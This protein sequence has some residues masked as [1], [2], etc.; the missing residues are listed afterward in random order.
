MAVVYH[1]AQL[2]VRRGARILWALR[3][4]EFRGHHVASA[5][6]EQAVGGQAVAARAPRLLIVGIEVLRHVVV[7][8]VADVGLVYAHAEGVGRDHDR[9]AVVYEF[10]LIARALRVG[11][12][13]VVAHGL[14]AFFAQPL[15]DL[16][17]GLARGA[18]DYSRGV[19]ELADVAHHRGVFVVGALDVEE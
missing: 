15:A 14:D 8:D 19:R 11:Q 9:G 17:D 13:R 16:F 6:E 4:E 7:Q 12:A 2:F 5:V 3:D 10:L 1:R 18:V